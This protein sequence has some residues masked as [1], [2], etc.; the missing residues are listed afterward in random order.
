MHLK[1]FCSRC[2]GWA[3]KI[4]VRTLP[5]KEIGYGKTTLL[6]AKHG[7]PRAL[8]G[9]A[10]NQR[11]LLTLM[12]RRRSECLVVIGSGGEAPVLL[13]DKVKQ[14]WILT[15]SRVLFLGLFLY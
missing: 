7:V 13:G 14:E 15:L 9:R 10:G 11:I 2:W 12:E 1:S 4:V 8:L 6:K 5:A 3:E